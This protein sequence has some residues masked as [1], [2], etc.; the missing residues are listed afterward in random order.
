MSPLIRHSIT[1]EPHLHTDLTLDE[2][3]SAALVLM[4]VGCQQLTELT[5][6]R[7]FE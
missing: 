1:S 7:M 6:N 3:S 5:L 4:M 2:A